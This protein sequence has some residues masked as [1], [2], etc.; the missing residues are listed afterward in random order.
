[1][2]ILKCINILYFTYYKMSVFYHHFHSKF[3]P[4]TI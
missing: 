4:H 1:M 2:Y 3:G